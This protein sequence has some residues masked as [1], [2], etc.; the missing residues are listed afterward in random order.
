MQSATYLVLKS[1][2]MPV[3]ELQQSQIIKAK[4]GENIPKMAQAV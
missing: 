1:Y 4:F 3:C 2:Y